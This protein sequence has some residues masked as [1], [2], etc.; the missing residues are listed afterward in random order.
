MAIYEEDTDSTPKVPE[1]FATTHWSVVWRAREKDPVAS[2]EAREKL[3]RTY[4]P[5]L[6][7]YLRRS[8]HSVHDA[9]DLTQQFLS[10]FLEK[11]WLNHLQDQRGKFRSFLLTFLKN[12]LSDE[13]GRAQ[14]LKRG[15]GRTLV[16][17]TPTR[18]RN[19][20]SRFQPTV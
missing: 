9:Q 11:E 3:C 4:W 15:G 10:C 5:P 2:A 6:Y 16:P 13:R 8:G 18:Q 14:A 20:S 19:A 12:F 7:A 1:V 17:S